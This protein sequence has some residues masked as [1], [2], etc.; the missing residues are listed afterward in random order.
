MRLTRW[1]W[2]SFQDRRMPQVLDSTLPTAHVIS[3]NYR[4]NAPIHPSGASPNRHVG[5]LPQVD[6]MLGLHPDGD[7]AQDAHSSG[8]AERCMES[9]AQVDSEDPF[10]ASSQ[11]LQMKSDSMAAV[12]QPQRQPKSRSPSAKGTPQRSFHNVCIGRHISETYRLALAAPGCHA[13]CSAYGLHCGIEGI[14]LGHISHYRVSECLGSTPPAH[15]NR[16]FH[17]HAVC[18]SLAD[19][20]SETLER[21]PHYHRRRRHCAAEQQRS[22]AEGGR[23]TTG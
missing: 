21:C 16:L 12:E 18:Q 10:A 23:A 19:L 2:P 3:R 20:T 8:N 5:Y 9:L 1:E 7:K 4:P 15:L 14:W 22:Q 11:A 13:G 6:D 17:L